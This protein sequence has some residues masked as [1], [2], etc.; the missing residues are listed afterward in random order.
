MVCFGSKADMSDVRDE[1][2]PPGRMP[3]KPLAEGSTCER[4]VEPL[5]NYRSQLIAAVASLS[6]TTSIAPAIL[7]SA[8]TPYGAMIGKNLS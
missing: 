3:V 7:L 4:Q 5:E 2:T 1:T 8:A 6:S